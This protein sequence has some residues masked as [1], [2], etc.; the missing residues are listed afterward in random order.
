VLID[1]DRD[2]RAIVESIGAGPEARASAADLREAVHAA[3][4]LLPERYARSL[5]WKYLE[6]LSVAD[7]AA[8]LGTSA[9][10][11]ESV[12]TR[13]RDAFREVF[14]ALAARGARPRTQP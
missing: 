13:A 4:D 9:K 12:L 3:L 5:E 8:R 14:H 10:A 6:D 11:A 7:V 2:L 1:D